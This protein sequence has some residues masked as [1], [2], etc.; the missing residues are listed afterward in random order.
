MRSFPFTFLTDCEVPS[1]HYSH[2]STHPRSG[3]L[4]ERGYGQCVGASVSLCGCRRGRTRGC[5]L[6]QF[7]TKAA[8]F[9]TTTSAHLGATRLSERPV[10]AP[11]LA[12][13]EY[14]FVSLS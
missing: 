12:G 1:P 3:I 6:S 10:A 4:L 14:Q 13:M 8:S 7:Q 11:S 9:P 5:P 2:A